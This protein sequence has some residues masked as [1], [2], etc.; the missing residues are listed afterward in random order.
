MIALSSCSHFDWFGGH[1]R[2]LPTFAC[3]LNVVTGTVNLCCPAACCAPDGSCLQVLTHADTCH[4]MGLIDEH[5]RVHA[6]EV[7]I[8]VASMIAQGEPNNT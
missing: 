3:S 2:L 4:A 5:E 6:M 7:Q 1:F 8:Q